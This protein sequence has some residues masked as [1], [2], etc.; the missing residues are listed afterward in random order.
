M[1]MQRTKLKWI[2][3][4]NNDTLFYS[5]SSDLEN[6]FICSLEPNIPECEMLFF[7]DYSLRP[8]LAMLLL[9]SVAKLER[10]RVPESTVYGNWNVLEQQYVIGTCFNICERA[11]SIKVRLLTLGIGSY[12]DSCMYSY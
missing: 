8:N 6:I 10:R 3:R 9:S 2:V 5:D 11:T 12:W 4:E 7:P 1:P